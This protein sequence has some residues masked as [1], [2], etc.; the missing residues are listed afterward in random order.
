MCDRLVAIEDTS[1]VCLKSLVCVA[2]DISLS[3]QL[4][5]CY[6]KF[7]TYSVT[8]TCHYYTVVHFSFTHCSALFIYTMTHYYTKTHLS[9]RQDIT[10]LTH[11]QFSSIFIQL[12][13]SSHIKSS[14]IMSN[15]KSNIM[16]NIIS[17]IMS[18]V[19]SPSQSWYK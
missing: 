7:V 3:S 8:S 19:M 9:I 15:I 4:M 10:L 5:F 16:S 18:Q 2:S 14:K 12:S 11:F 1:L 13:L 6:H 17:N